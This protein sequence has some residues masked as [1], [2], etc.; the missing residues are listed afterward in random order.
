MTIHDMRLRFP[1]LP[2]G[3]ETMWR[4]LEAASRPLEDLSI[5]EH[6]DRHRK[7]SP[8]SGSPWPGDFRTDRVPG[9]E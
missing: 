4:G 5:S 7:V 6:S 8:E 1:D 9:S 3:A 2:D